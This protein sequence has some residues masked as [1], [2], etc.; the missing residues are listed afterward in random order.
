MPFKKRVGNGLSGAKGK[1]FIQTMSFSGLC[2]NAGFSAVDAP[3]QLINSMKS[4]RFI[5]PPGRKN[6]SRSLK[7]STLREGSEGKRSKQWTRCAQ[8][9]RVSET[10]PNPDPRYSERAGGKTMRAERLT[11]HV[12]FSLRNGH[13]Q[14]WAAM[15]AKC[16]FCCRNR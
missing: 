8:V 11:C 3:T 10:G 1:A 7:P 6:A 4:R 14:L 2:A 12:W 15:S 13:R 16:R 5:A 9:H